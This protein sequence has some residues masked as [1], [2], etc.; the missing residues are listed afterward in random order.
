MGREVNMDAARKGKLGATGL[1][2]GT[3]KEIQVRDNDR[4]RLLKVRRLASGLH[5][6]YRSIDRTIHQASFADDWGLMTKDQREEVEKCIREHNRRGLK[7][8]VKQ[9]R[10]A[11]YGEQTMESLRELGKIRSIPRYSRLTRVE[12]IQAL[13]G[14]EEKE[15]D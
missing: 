5:L 6:D 8:C 4:A 1:L 15:E 9:S 2:G 3:E 14:K 7:R 13:E 10:S 12:L 11:Y